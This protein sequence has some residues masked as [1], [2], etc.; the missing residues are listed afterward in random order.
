MVEA[1]YLSSTTKSDKNEIAM[2][3]T[4][5]TTI[6]MKDTTTTTIDTCSNK[7]VIH[8]K[9]DIE[10]KD[11]GM[12]IDK[13]GDG[14][15]NNCDNEY[16]DLLDGLD[17]I[18]PMDTNSNETFVKSSYAEYNKNIDNSNNKNIDDNTDRINDSKCVG[19]NC[20]D[21]NMD[22]LEGMDEFNSLDF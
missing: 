14:V 15:Y 2:K 6:N 10:K 21:S 16:I 7:S 12:D 9:M 3:D 5:T 19:K 17:D 4:T 8:S 18:H 20:G 22:L 1:K 13:K 11:D